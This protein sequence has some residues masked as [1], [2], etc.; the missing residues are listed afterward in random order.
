VESTTVI[1][2]NEQVHR[3][4]ASPVGIQNQRQR[5]LRLT[6]LLGLVDW[7]I[8]EAVEQSTSKAVGT[9]VRWVQFPRDPFWVGKYGGF[10]FPGVAFGSASFSAAQRH[11]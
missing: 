3:A 11:K 1:P 10:N 9:S 8:T 5:R 4:A 6:R 2:Q 7:R